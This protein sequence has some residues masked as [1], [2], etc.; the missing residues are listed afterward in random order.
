MYKSFAPWIF[1]SA[2]FPRKSMVFALFFFLAYKLTVDKLPRGIYLYNSLEFCNSCN[3]RI[4]V[5]FFLL[6]VVFPN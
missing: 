5:K 1:S 3:L 6:P 2:V 4:I